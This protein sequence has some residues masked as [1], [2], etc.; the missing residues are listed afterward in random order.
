MLQAL[1]QDLT[2]LKQRLQA[3]ELKG[4]KGFV[5]HAE[6]LQEMTGVLA[7]PERPPESKKRRLGF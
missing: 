7:K 4:V 5:V 1:F 6:D 3:L 2:D